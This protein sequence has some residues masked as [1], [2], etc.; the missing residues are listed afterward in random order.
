MP[1]GA[2]SFLEG[3]YSKAKD[4]IGSG[5]KLAE[6][7]HR[8][9]ALKTEWGEAFDLPTR[10]KGEGGAGRRRQDHRLDAESP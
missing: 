4:L 6:F 8:L 2:Q 9:E 5:E 10:E 7:R 3:D 1:G